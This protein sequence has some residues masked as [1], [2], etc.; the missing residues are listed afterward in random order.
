MNEQIQGK[1]MF[2]TPILSRS[3]T[4]GWCELVKT[5]VTEVKEISSPA[6]KAP[7]AV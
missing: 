2:N 1:K 6:G 3:L 5:V 7:A 4:P